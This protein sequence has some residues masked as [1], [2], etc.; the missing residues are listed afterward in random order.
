M[1]ATIF[2]NDIMGA[3]LCAWKGESVEGLLTTV[4]GGMM[5]N[6]IIRLTQIKISCTDPARNRAGVCDKYGRLFLYYV[7]VLLCL[8]F[9]AF[10]G[11]VI[12]RTAATYNKKQ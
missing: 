9:V 5:N 12:G 3:D 8:L 6:Y 11:L 7:C 2:T 1:Y 10:I 4:L